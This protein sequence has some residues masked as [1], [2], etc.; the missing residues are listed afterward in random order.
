LTPASAV[1]LTEIIHLQGM[2]GG[3]FNLVL[4]CGSKVGDAMINSKDVNGVS[5]TGSVDTGPK[6]AAATAPNF[7]RC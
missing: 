1:A 3:T 4:G 5:F 6:V 2:A 7:V